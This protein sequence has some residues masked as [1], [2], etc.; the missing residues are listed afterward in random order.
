MPKFF[1]IDAGINYGCVPSDLLDIRWEVNEFSAD[2]ALLEDEKHLIRV[3]FEGNTIVR[4]LD[5]MPLSTENDLAEVD[6]LVPHHFAYRVEGAPFAAIQSEAWKRVVGSVHHYQ[7]VTGWGCL[8][9]LS[10]REPR[11][12]LVEV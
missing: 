6:G 12:E 3:S 8:D 4:I 5:E 7:F 9:V 1:P 11:I 2:F 10:G